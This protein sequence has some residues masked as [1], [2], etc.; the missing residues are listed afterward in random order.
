[1]RTKSPDTMNKIKEY[2]SSHQENRQEQSQS[3][4]D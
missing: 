1:M 3:R 2:L 4:R